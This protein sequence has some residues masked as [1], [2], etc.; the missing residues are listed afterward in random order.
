M[1]TITVPLSVLIEAAAAL[2]AVVTS[3]GS[4]SLPSALWH[5]CLA[6]RSALNWR[7]DMLVAAAAPVEVMPELTADAIDQLQTNAFA[8][9]IKHAIEEAGV[10]A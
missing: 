8:E 2:N 1:T 6:A 7:V 3:A 9:G 4:D 10:P 5:K